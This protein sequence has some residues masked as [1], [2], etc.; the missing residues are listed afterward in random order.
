MMCKQ[1]HHFSIDAVGC[2]S[3]RRKMSWQK[4]TPLWEGMSYRTRGAEQH[5][6]CSLG[7]SIA[8]P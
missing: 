6:I 8:V 2:L 3:A 5:S 1:L 4:A 7:A